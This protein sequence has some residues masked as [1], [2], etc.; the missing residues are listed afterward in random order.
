MT[1]TV[2]RT[3]SPARDR[4]GRSETGLDDATDDEQ[5]NDEQEGHDHTS[6]S[7]E[8]VLNG[9]LVKWHVGVLLA[10]HLEILFV[11]EVFRLQ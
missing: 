11:V 5:A 1:G 6:P 7:Q 2:Y 10:E 9:L 3:D 4:A 8:L